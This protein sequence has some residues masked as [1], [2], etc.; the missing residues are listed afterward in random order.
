MRRPATLKIKT[1]SAMD[2]QPSDYDGGRV[3]IKKLKVH[4]LFTE[5]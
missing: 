3:P 1:S 4:Y 2:E 5:I